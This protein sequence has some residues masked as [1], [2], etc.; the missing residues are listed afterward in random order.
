LK[1]RTT[2]ADGA[3]AATQATS[4]E[5]IVEQSG[6]ETPLSLIQMKWLSSRSQSIFYIQG[7]KASQNRRPC[8][9]SSICIYFLFFICFSL[10]FFFVDEH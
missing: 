7:Y 6:G 5:T 1:E 3:V 9:C 4:V 2:S 8:S 10:F